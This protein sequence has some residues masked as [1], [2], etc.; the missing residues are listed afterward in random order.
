MTIERRFEIKDLQRHYGFTILYATHDQSEA[1]ALSD[2]SMVMK[3]SVV[4][5]IDTPANAYAHPATYSYSASSAC[6]NPGRARGR[7]QGAY[8]RQS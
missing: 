6:P 7:R 1:M 5:Q 4:Q 2:R 3:L 8:Q